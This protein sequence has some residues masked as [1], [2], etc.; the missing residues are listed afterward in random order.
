MLHPALENQHS[1][2]AIDSLASF[3]DRQFSFAQKAIG[4]GRGQAL[5]PQMHGQP[6]FFDEI[7]SEGAHFF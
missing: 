5:V 2:H 4:F 7:V 3:L 1:G 6:E